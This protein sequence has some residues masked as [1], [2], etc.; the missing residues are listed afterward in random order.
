MPIIGTYRVTCHESNALPLTKQCHGV[1][2]HYPSDRARNG[3]KS[4]WLGSDA[5]WDAKRSYLDL[6]LDGR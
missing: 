5:D 3:A 1:C 2:N 4:A 6:C